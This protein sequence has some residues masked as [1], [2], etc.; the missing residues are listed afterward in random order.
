MDKIIDKI[1][2][3]MKK[4]GSLE[5]DEEIVRYGLEIVIMKLIFVIIIL[6]TGL[7]MNCFIESIFFTAV[8]S[9]LR[10]YAGGCHADSRIK[11]FIN[12]IL[13]LAVA[14]IG[15]K[16]SEAFGMANIILGILSV[17]S[18]VYIFI[19]APIDTENKRLDREE[20]CHY[21]RRARVL[22]VIFVLLA[23][24][25]LILKINNVACAIMM[26]IVVE[27]VLMLEG[28]IKNHKAGGIYE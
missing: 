9:A 20:I 2:S 7:M 10:M 24:I 11:C 13:T 22:T 15:I 3:I 23:V 12:S 26:G 16:A 8:Y 18:A 19:T 25:L 6:V 21:G 4:N 27:A 1:I 14:L 17:I 5:T 28:Y